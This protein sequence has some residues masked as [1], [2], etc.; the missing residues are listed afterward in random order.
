MVNS[1]G[2]MLG[3]GMKG[4]GRRTGELNVVGRL[5]NRA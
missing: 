5:L 1:G 2:A 4:E 3:R